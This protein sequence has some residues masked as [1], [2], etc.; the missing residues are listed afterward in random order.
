[1]LVSI[2][3]F[4]I[5]VWPD[6]LL[7]P[8]GVCCEKVQGSWFRVQGLGLFALVCMVW[9]WGTRAH[10]LKKIAFASSLGIQGAFLKSF[11]VQKSRDQ[12]A[13]FKKNAFASSLGI[14]HNQAA[15]RAV[16]TDKPFASCSE[17]TPPPPLARRRPR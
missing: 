4:F 14:R 15:R 11:L 13:F 1:L 6:T 17:S 7:R 16:Q 10:F 3:L 5:A 2:L 8:I 12:G 9:R